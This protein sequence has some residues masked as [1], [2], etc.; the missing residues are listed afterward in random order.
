[1]L[2]GA[3]G[4]L[5]FART[6]RLVPVEA[7]TFLEVKILGITQQ[8]KNFTMSLSK[9]EARRFLPAKQGYIHVWKFP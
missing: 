7:E 3:L 9:L 1:M 8:A 6:T 2:Q 5:K 4:S